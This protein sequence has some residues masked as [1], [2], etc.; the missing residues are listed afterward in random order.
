MPESTA[1]SL[2]EEARSRVENLTPAQVAGELEGDVL[3]VDLREPEEVLANGR[4]VGSVRAPRGGLEF[5]ADPTHRRHRPEFH[6]SRRVILFSTS[7]AR[8][9]LAADTLQRMGYRRVAH[10]DG[11]LDAWKKAGLPVQR[12]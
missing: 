10:L 1:A 11:G 2:V 4:I 7:G 12:T 8:S 5:W 6:P 9:A 3:L